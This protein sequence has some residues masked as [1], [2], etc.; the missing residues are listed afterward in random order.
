M[1]AAWQEWLRTN[2]SPDSSVAD[3]KKSA[4]TDNPIIARVLAAMG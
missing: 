3:Q 2:P 1:P 4:L